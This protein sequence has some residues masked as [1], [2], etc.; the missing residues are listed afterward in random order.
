MDRETERFA[1]GWKGKKK[2]QFCSAYAL[3]SEKK[4]GNNSSQ[5]IH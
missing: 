3:E 1:T 2:P 5:L 4:K